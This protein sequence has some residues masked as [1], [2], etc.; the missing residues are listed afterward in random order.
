[1]DI[2]NKRTSVTRLILD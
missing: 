2:T 1:M